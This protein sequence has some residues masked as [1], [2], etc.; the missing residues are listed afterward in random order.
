[1]GK[2]VNDVYGISRLK[3]K[4]SEQAIIQLM[5]KNF[6]LAPKVAEAYYSEVKQY[7]EEHTTDRAKGGETLYEAIDLDEP[8]G[9]AIKDSRRR[10][11]K[12]TFQTTED[13]KILKKRGLPELRRHKIQRFCNEAI[14]QGAILTYED[15]AQLLTTSIGTIKSDARLLRQRGVLIPTRGREKD[16]GK[17]ISH[18]AQAIDLYLQKYPFSEIAIRLHHSSESIE[19]YLEE[20]RRV[21]YLKENGIRP[22][23]IRLITKRSKKLINQYLAIYQKAKKNRKKYIRLPDFE[24]WLKKGASESLLSHE[25][26]AI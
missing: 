21:V 15:L 14:S 7:F 24:K 17:T 25:K 26:E 8:A 6:N 22:P 13:F 2:R 9:K 18:K 4:N 1:M 20:F 11:I 23:Q 16:I 10:L 3:V 19:R 5:A 12:L